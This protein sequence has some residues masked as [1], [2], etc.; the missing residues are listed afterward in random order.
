MIS[1]M[2]GLIPAKI[3]WLAS[4]G[5]IILLRLRRVGL[6]TTASNRLASGA[7]TATAV[8]IGVMLVTSQY[9]SHA[10]ARVLSSRGLTVEKLMVA[11]TPVTPFV[12]DV[13]AQTPYA[14]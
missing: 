8:Y 12:R 2:P 13:V 1:S 6:D 10:V 7:V 9:A 3:L 11:P 4:L 5:E 14:Y